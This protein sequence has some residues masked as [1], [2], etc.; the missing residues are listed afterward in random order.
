MANMFIERSVS[1]HLCCAPS[2]TPTTVRKGRALKIVPSMGPYERM[3]IG[4][5]L[6]L[7]AL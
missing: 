6:L 1:D 2:G 5:R 3:V 7:N 4:Q